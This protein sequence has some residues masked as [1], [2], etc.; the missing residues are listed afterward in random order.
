M[1]FSWKFVRSFVLPE[2]WEDKMAENAANRALA[3]AYIAKQLG[4]SAE[5]LR[6]RDRELEKPSMAEVRFKRYKNE[7]DEKVHPTVIVALRAA[8]I[9]VQSLSSEVPKFQGSSDALEIRNS[10]LRQS[11]YVDLDSLL[12]YCWQAGIVVLQLANKPSG[13]KGFD[14]LAASVEGRPV[15]ILASGRDSAP[16]LAFYL[17]HEVG[18]IMLEHVQPGE[19]ALIDKSLESLA[20]QDDQERQ[21]NRFALEVLAGHATP[22]LRNLRVRAEQLAVIAAGRAR[23]LGIDPGVY[24]LIY[25]S[26]N[27][28]WAAAQKALRVLG[29]DSGGKVKVASLLDRLVDHDLLSEADEHFLGVLQQP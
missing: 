26:S 2:W 29:L 10:I 24:A 17:A 21:A 25:A 16:W 9:V 1:G 28:R 27:N 18:H 5:D 8:Q 22:T 19:G 12:E 13:S 7:V 23:D 20:G 15:I 4:F 3:E 6:Q 11:E 14:G